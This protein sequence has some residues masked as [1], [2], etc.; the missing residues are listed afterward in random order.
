M[1]ITGL[2]YGDEQSKWNSLLHGVYILMGKADKYKQY[3]DFRR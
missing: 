1:L 2:A 3:I